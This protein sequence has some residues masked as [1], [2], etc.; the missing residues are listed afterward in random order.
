[1]IVEMMCERPAQL[2]GLTAVKGTLAVGKQADLVV[3]DPEASHKVSESD[4]FSRFAD[5]CIYKDKTLKGKVRATFLRGTQIY[6]DSEPSL[7]Y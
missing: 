6:S 7:I 1:M 2:L 5:V 4:I 3:F